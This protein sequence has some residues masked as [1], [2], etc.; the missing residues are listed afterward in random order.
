MKLQSKTFLNSCRLN[1]PTLSFVFLKATVHLWLLSKTVFSFGVSKHM[2]TLTNQ[3][4][5]GL[6]C[7]SKLQENI[8]GKQYCYT[9][10]CAFRCTRKAPGRQFVQIQL[11]YLNEK[12]SL[13]QKL[14]LQRTSFY[15]LIVTDNTQ[16]VACL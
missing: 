10:L 15:T 13:S 9:Y 1:A 4:A 12:L 11:K 16:S 2:H 14:L 7:S 8:G 6:N 5:F 3:W